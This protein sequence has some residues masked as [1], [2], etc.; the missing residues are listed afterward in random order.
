MLNHPKILSASLLNLKI[1]LFTSYN[2]E[3]EAY[4]DS[5]DKCGMIPMKL[6]E[7]FI[8]LAQESDLESMLTLHTNVTQ[9]MPFLYNSCSNGIPAAPVIPVGVCLK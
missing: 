1:F 8:S 6:F 7:N 5:Y 4:L 2:K 9:Q 3:T